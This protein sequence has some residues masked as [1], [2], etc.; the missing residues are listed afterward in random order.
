MHWTQNRLS[1]DGSPSSSPY[2]D[3]PNRELHEMSEPIQYTRNI[4]NE[5][6]VEL[7]AERAC[8]CITNSNIDHLEKVAMTDENRNY[9]RPAVREYDG[10]YHFNDNGNNHRPKTIIPVLQVSSL[11]DDSKEKLALR[12]QSSAADKNRRTTSP[13]NSISPQTRTQCEQDKWRGVE[14]ETVEKMY[15]LITLIDELEKHLR[16]K[17][18]KTDNSSFIIPGH[19]KL[20]M[21][22]SKEKSTRSFARLLKSKREK[23]G[24]MVH[25]PDCLGSKDQDASNRENVINCAKPIQRS[26]SEHFVQTL[27]I[28]APCQTS[29]AWTTDNESAIFDKWIEKLK[30]MEKNRSAGE[31]G[32]CPG[33]RDGSHTQIEPLRRMTLKRAMKAIYR[34]VRM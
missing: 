3:R 16:L 4:S 7:I 15:M 17:Q 22:R 5:S 14:K 24:K 31:M 32:T 19:L 33:N 2:I 27:H 13:A 20:S 34:R 6:N 12:G 25:V 26:S 28:P 30:I 8:G 21:L 29:V 11:I 23:R 18:N 10:S 9:N 1:S